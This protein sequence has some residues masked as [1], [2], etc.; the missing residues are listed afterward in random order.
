MGPFILLMTSSFSLLIA[1]V[2]LV[3]VALGNGY[4]GKKVREDI[5]KIKEQ[6]SGG[7]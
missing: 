7:S 1:F 4:K 5:R 3:L 6:I 2:V